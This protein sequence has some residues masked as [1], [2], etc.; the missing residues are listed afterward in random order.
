[1]IVRKKNGCCAALWVLVSVS[2]WARVAPKEL[3]S[4]WCA[5]DNTVMTLGAFEGMPNPTT[6]ESLC[7]EFKLVR[8]SQDGG[9]GRYI[10]TRQIRQGN[11]YPVKRHPLE[12]YNVQTQTY[13]L[14]IPG[15]F[16]FYVNGDGA[17][18]MTDRSLSQPLLSIAGTMDRS[19]KLK[20][21]LTYGTKDS[22]IDFASV[23]Y[24]ALENDRHGVDNRFDSRWEALRTQVAQLPG[25]A[26]Q[27]VPAA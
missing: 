11:Q 15:L 12:Q 10:L 20:V 4:R 21:T 5:P 26:V 24:A 17:V 16:A 25:S 9:I 6:T 27:E 1:M 22:Q 19:R 7:M 14:A 23:S 2:V 13:E 8:S 3:E 18:V